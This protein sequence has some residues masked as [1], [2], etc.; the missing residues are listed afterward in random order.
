MRRSAPR[1]KPV[2]HEIIINKF[3]SPLS[4]K[5]TNKKIDADSIND[6]LHA[7]TL[8]V[9]LERYVQK[10]THKTANQK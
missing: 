8:L 5:T 9:F 6:T 10:G 3:R 2:K 1:H 4:K 7:K